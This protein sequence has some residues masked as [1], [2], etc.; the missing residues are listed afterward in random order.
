MFINRLV[1]L[2][3]FFS[4]SAHA[5]LNIQNWKTPNGSLKFILLKTIVYPSLTLMLCSVR[6]V[7]EI[8]NRLMA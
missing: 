4:S 3:L 8:R 2:I 5:E 1:L 7:S 6:E